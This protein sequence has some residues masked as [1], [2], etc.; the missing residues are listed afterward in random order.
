MTPTRRSFIRLVPVA[1]LT[2]TAAISAAAAA[3]RPAPLPF[4]PPKPPPAPA[5][6]PKRDFTV[7]DVQAFFT[8]EDTQAFTRDI[9]MQALA[10]VNQQLVVGRLVRRTFEG[11]L[12]QPGDSVNIPVTPLKVS[13]DQS[14]GNGGP[15]P[16]PSEDLDG[17][18]WSVGGASDGTM[19]FSMY[20]FP[21]PWKTG[22]KNEEIRVPLRNAQIVLKHCK[23]TFVLANITSVFNHPEV[24][25]VH[26]QPAAF[27]LA[28][29]IESDLMAAAGSFPFLW[30]PSSHSWSLEQRMDAAETALFNA[31]VPDALPKHLIVDGTTYGDLR[32]HPRFSEGR[33][34]GFS[35]VHRSLL[36]RHPAFA[37]TSDAMALITRRLPLPLPGTG[38][39]GA[40]AET[41]DFGIRAVLGWDPRSLGQQITIDVL[42][43]VGV[44]RRQFGVQ[45]NDYAAARTNYSM[46]R[47][48]RT[49]LQV[50]VV[51]ALSQPPNVKTIAMR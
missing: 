3:T 37:F 51:P 42:Y 34:K 50:Q 11:D 32:K 16:F 5:P 46:S 14:I 25:R 49:Y 40:Y 10:E 8:V 29:G 44:L 20:N 35:S 33:F 39:I 1:A 36:A 17:N 13:N 41:E 6:L 45:L 24:L 18:I 48:E 22:T 19:A 28:E 15:G 26:L 9:A 47:T 31:Q 43:G 23:A 2:A 21:R 27:A 7:E 38:A 4:S 12:A 30:S